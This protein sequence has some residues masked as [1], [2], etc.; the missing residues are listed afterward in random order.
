MPSKILNYLKTM[1]ELIWETVMAWFNDN[2]T[3]QGAALAFYTLFSLA[4]LLIIMTV[5]VGYFL[6]QKAVQEYLLAQLSSY[7]GQENARNIITA[8][9]S[10]YKPGSGFFATIIAIF[11]M[12]FGSSSVF[13]MMKSALNSIWG[14]RLEFEGYFFLIVDRL[15]SFLA[16]LLL[17]LLLLISM[18]IK[19]F[20]AAFYKTISNYLVVPGFLLELINQ[21]FTLIFL[22]FLFAIL[23]KILPDVKVPWRYA[24]RGALVTALLFI[25]GNIF[26]GLYL[27]RQGIA[28]AYGAAGSLVIILLWVY[29]SA[30]I[31]FLGAEFTQVYARRNGYK[32]EAKDSSFGTIKKVFT[33]K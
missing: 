17:G 29:Y 11:L 21:T 12:F 26:L 18:V 19:S 24:I 23:Y 32:I 8:I 14:V 1:W 28:S 31:T 4:P 7:V 20:L 25:V 10:T 9:Q 6:G 5:V 16:L 27:T 13:L 30:L 33:W 2:A 22:S 3:V 15:K